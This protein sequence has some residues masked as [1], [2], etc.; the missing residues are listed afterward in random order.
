MLIIL[1]IALRLQDMFILVAAC[2]VFLGIAY[3]IDRIRDELR[4]GS[5]HA[6]NYSPWEMP[7]L[8]MFVAALIAGSWYMFP[9]AI[10]LLGLKTQSAD[11]MEAISEVS[12]LIMTALS[13]ISLVYFLS[14]R[15]ELVNMLTTFH[16]VLTFSSCLLFF[17]YLSVWE[18]DQALMFSG[19]NDS[20]HLYIRPL[21]SSDVGMDMSIICF[22]VTQLS[23]IV[24]VFIG[25]RRK[26]AN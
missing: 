20:R 7:E 14:R 15:L 23:L 25:I 1:K 18:Y 13:I 19:M 9:N 3:L 2:F 16:L 22:L 6:T 17:H 8:S 24:N 12:F 21:L 5:F 26:G 11:G 4:E 10:G